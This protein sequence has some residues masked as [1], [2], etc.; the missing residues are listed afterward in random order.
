MRWGAR[1]AH[2]RLHWYSKMPLGEIQMWAV[3][4]QQFRIRMQV[5]SVMDGTVGHS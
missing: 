2:V 3:L 5:Q 1:P 4:Q